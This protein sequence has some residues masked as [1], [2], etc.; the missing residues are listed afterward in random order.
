MPIKITPYQYFVY[1]SYE[2]NAEDEVNK[3]K[4][5]LSELT[6]TLSHEKDVVIDVSRCELL[7]SFEL[8]AIAKVL[9]CV[10]KSKRFLRVITNPAI[11]K[12][13][14][15]TAFTRGKEFCMY[16]NIQAFLDEVKNAQ[17]KPLPEPSKSG[18]ETTVV[19]YLMGS[20]IGQ[21]I[22]EMT[23]HVLV[24][25]RGP[26]KNVILDMSGVEQ[27]DTHCVVQLMHLDSTARQ[28]NKTFALTHLQ[29]HILDLLQKANA[30]QLIQ[31]KP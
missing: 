30:D 9:S 10:G 23:D 18:S 6:Q 20:I 4:N 12:L 19:V 27:I 21:K 16:E 31:I 26:H 13:L 28:Q 25:L 15:T 29:S 7:G 14:E 22:Q 17:G 24:A 5:A 8:G 2:K 11:K 3:F 1:V